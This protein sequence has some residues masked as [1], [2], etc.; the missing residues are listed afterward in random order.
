VITKPENFR[1]PISVLR[2]INRIRAEDDRLEQ[3]R[4]R[5]SEYNG[6]VEPVEGTARLFI[7]QAD[8]RRNERLT[9]VRQWLS[10]S[11]DDPLWESDADEADV[12]VLVLVH[13]MAARR[14]G[15]ADIYAALNDN[16][17]T[18][19]KDGLLDGTA[20]VLRP[21][22]TNLLPLVLA[23]RDG[24]DF[25]VI[26]ALRSNCPLLTSERLVGQNAVE[27]LLRMKSAVDRL[28]EMLSGESNHLIRDVLAFVRDEELA[29]L[30]ERF[31]SYLVEQPVGES[32][33]TEPEV[34][35]VRAFLT[36]PAAQLWGY[37]TYVEDQ[38]PFATQQ[39]IKGAEFQRVLVVLDDEESQYNLFSYGKYF[40]LEPLSDKDQ[41][42]IHDHVDSVMDRTRRLFYVC[43]SRAVQDLAVVLFVP[44]VRMA[45]DVLVE[46]GL[47]DRN[48]VHTLE[49]LP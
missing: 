31:L 17:A 48:D 14:L 36:C 19:L 3:V 20:W 10:Q 41:E 18:S 8:A 25:D 2:V 27:L 37:R 28:V 13:R 24:A 44:D 4:G 34:V 39:G 9:Q 33:E 40:G 38:S 6:V 43:C 12:R 21:F 1:C 42:N 26:A 46:R 16:G 30:D 23:A 5:T 22:M 15:F 45:T 29:D 7:I 11:N 35:A 32:D 47:F 49:D